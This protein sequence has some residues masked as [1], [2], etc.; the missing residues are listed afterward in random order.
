MSDGERFTYCHHC[1]QF[2]GPT[3][4]HDPDCPKK[5]ADGA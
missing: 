3:G 1:H 5:E 4:P 2:V